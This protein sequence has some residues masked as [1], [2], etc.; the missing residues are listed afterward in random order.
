[1]G[2]KSGRV[3]WA[4]IDR[5]SNQ[6]NGVVNKKNGGHYIVGPVKEEAVSQTVRVRKTG[7]HRAELVD[8]DLQK[9]SYAAPV[10][11]DVSL[12]PGTRLS[13]RLMKSIEGTPVLEQ[14]SY[15]IEVPDG[16][17]N[18]FVEVE[19][20]EPIEQGPQWVTAV[21]KRVDVDAPSETEPGTIV[22][23][24]EIYSE[25]PRTPS[26]PVSCPVPGCDYTGSAASV[27][28]HVSG[29]KDTKHDWNRLGYANSHEFK[30][31]YIETTQYLQGQTEILH[32]S[33]SHLGSTIID[34]E[35]YSM[36]HPCL[37]SFHQAIELAIERNVDAVLNTGDLFHNDRR[38]I[39]EAVEE[40]A[41][42][43]FQRLANA[44]IPLYSITGNHERKAG[45]EILARFEREGLVTRLSESAVAVGDGIALYGRDFAKAEEWQSSQWSPRRC[46]DAR[47]GIVAVHQSITPF[48]PAERAECSTED[49]NSMAGSQIHAVAAGHL[50]KADVIWNSN[51]PF[52]IGDSTEPKRAA[53]QEGPTVGCFVQDCGALHYHRV[54]I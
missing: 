28:G 32:F 27:A 29:K 3:F 12:T 7:P 23:E 1:M 22:E 49:I 13:G 8:K 41:A 9:G 54:R 5:I 6:G 39:P 37:A 34:E 33:D 44:S 26:V 25:F 35:D 18:E 15:R 17:L 40:A 30:D 52:V 50:H 38:G 53:G 2:R 51:L 11:G 36:D 20:V 19:V 24:T 4:T 42:G 14:D 47:F 45:R 46:Q 21:G 31:K 48:S 43:A 16:E 10:D